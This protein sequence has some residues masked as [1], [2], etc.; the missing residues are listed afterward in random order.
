MRTNHAHQK[1]LEE[2]YEWTS[3]RAKKLVVGWKTLGLLD[4]KSFLKWTKKGG[5]LA[6]ENYE[7]EDKSEEQEEVDSGVEA[8]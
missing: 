1:Y 2:V 3:T 8:E 4:E 5:M 7:D 6:Y